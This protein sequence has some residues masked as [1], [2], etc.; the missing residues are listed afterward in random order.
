MGLSCLEGWWS[1][2]RPTYRFMRAERGGRA[3]IGVYII[4]PS[5]RYIVTSVEHRLGA[6]T[7]RFLRPTLDG[8]TQANL[9]VY[10]GL[11][12]VCRLWCIQ[13]IICSIALSAVI[14]YKT[15]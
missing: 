1:G 2:G 11:A 5:I 8:Q 4:I 14:D 15:I 10:L 12:S 7:V 13:R 9:D 6:L 3:R